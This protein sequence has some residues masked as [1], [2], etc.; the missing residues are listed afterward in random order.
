MKTLPAEFNITSSCMRLLNKLQK[1]S[2][3]DNSYSHY[4]VWKRASNTSDLWRFSWRLRRWDWRFAGR[5][6][7]AQWSVV[8]FLSLHQDSAHD[9]QNAPNRL[10]PGLTALS[11]LLLVA[12]I[13]LPE[14]FPGA[15]SLLSPPPPFLS[16]SF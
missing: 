11:L 8:G 10:F 3:V 14:Q 2:D 15:F 16:T 1:S 13:S 6:G 5:S 9:L 7:V 4:G 12:S